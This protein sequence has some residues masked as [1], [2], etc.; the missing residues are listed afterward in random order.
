MVSA[1]EWTVRGV[2]KMLAPT[3]I[4]IDVLVGSGFAFSI[5][6]N[7]V[8]R[9]VNEYEDCLSLNNVAHNI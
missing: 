2:L 3:K 8:W 5:Y 6:S 9:L 1:I 7:R 4:V